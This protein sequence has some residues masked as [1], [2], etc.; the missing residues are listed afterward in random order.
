MAS[1]ITDFNHLPKKSLAPGLLMYVDY[2]QE[3]LIGAIAYRKGILSKFK[4]LS[5]SSKEE[6]VQFVVDKLKS[7]I[8]RLKETGYISPKLANSATDYISTVLSVLDFIQQDLDLYVDGYEDLIA[9]FFS[10]QMMMEM[11]NRF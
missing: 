2:T 5:E 10:L 4:I 3:R 9:D 1:E 8:E 11:N 6:D 7:E